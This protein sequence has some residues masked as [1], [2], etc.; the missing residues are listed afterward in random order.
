MKSSAKQ[1]HRKSHSISE[2][3]CLHPPR[4]HP[5]S[6]GRVAVAIVVS[7]TLGSI[8]ALQISAA[9]TVLSGL[10]A[11]ATGAGNV[12]CFESPGKSV[13]G[14]SLASAATNNPSVVH[15]S[16]NYVEQAITEIQAGNPV[17]A[18]KYSEKAV[19]ANP[20]SAIALAI[21]GLSQLHC[22]RWQEAEGWLNQALAL[23]SALPEVHL[24][25]A[26]I[27]L[28]RMQYSLAIAHSRRAAG[29]KYFKGAAYRVQALCLE[30]MN[31]HEQASQA[32]R[33]AYKW[34]DNLPD[35]DRENIQNWSEIFSSYEGRDLC[36]IAAD[37]RST[38]IPFVNYQGHA[39]L[40]V[41]ASG[42][43][44]DSFLLDT[45]FGG[46]LM[47]SPKDAD[48]LGLV[49]SG[50]ITTRTFYG[51]LVIKI[52]LFDSL[53]LGDLVV[54]N[55]PVYVCDIPGGFRGL[56]GWQLLKNLNF[57][58][59]FINSR[60]MMFNPKYPTLQK[61]LF[62]KGKHVD[63]IPFLYDK[64]NRIIAYFG[65]NGPQ[66]FIFD[67]GATFSALHVDTSN[68]TIVVGSESRTSIRIGNLLF[69]DMKV[70]YNDFSSIHERGRY[71]FDGIVGV[72]VFQN[73]V[74]HF[75]PGESAFY[76][77]CELID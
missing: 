9:D 59:D 18:L 41:T 45:G 40:P 47:I 56:I 20:D 55:V 36:A 69:N 52:G 63:R 5:L 10:A 3:V 11:K 67:T 39:L 33:E 21:F 38:V 66:Y 71:Y 42:Q 25:L 43:V 6:A 7:M 51:N 8:S 50:E 46:T 65:G 62:S 64:G 49:F 54:D 24:G 1:Y 70:Q 32:L 57:S 31:L 29:S 75:N 58:I 16:D 30:E 2:K 12:Y 73:S 61:D 44:L 74:L 4:P 53:R 72:N 19:A 22:C 77:E 23:D 68:D 37:F 26:E 28:D 60:I 15:V 14:S 13:G 27:A 48:N 76:V 34:S 17:S 35:Y